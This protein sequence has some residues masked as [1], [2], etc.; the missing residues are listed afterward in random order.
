MLWISRYE[1]GIYLWHLM[2]IDNLLERA[3]IIQ[4]LNNAGHKIVLTL[5]FIVIS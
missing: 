5:I 3:P 1:Y 2:I 4:N